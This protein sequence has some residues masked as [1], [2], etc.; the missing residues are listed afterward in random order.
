MRKENNMI[1][2]MILKNAVSVSEH[3]HV[4]VL[5]SRRTRSSFVMI[6]N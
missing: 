6:I 3:F 2:E 5:D 4:A 1:E